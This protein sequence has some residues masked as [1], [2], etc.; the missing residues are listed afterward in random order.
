MTDWSD[1]DIFSDAEEY[2]H[3]ENWGLEFWTDHPT[4]QA[5]DVDLLK[6]LSP[7]ALK[8]VAQGLAATANEEMLAKFRRMNAAKGGAAKANATMSELEVAK[9]CWRIEDELNAK[10][11]K[12]MSQREASRRVAPKALEV[13]RERDP[14]RVSLSPSRVRTL[15]RMRPE[16]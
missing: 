11:E 16:N 5:A 12:P 6:R 10:R 13:L 9:V 3:A 15:L 8:A 4:F 7:Y 1:I 14:E 2:W